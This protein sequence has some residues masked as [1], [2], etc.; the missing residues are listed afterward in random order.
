MS[1]VRDLQF[2]K[3]TKKTHCRKLSNET[4]SDS[5]DSVICA[6]GTHMRMR[7]FHAHE[8]IYANPMELPECTESRRSRTAISDAK[9]D[10]GAESRFIIQ[11]DRK[12]L[13]LA[14]KRRDSK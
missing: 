6:W 8:I 3:L 10:H 4:E 12:G 5:V 7:F 1:T 14:V 2:T 9:M 11:G 13:E